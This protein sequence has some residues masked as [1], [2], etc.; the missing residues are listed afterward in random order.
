MTNQTVQQGGRCIDLLYFDVDHGLERLLFLT[1]NREL[2]TVDFRLET[3]P[4]PTYD[5]DGRD[6]PTASLRGATRCASV[7]QFDG[8]CRAL[9]AALRETP[10]SLQDPGRPPF[11][12]LP[13]DALRL[14]VMGPGWL[15]S[16]SPAEFRA[17]LP[18]NSY[19]PV[20]RD[21]SRISCE[22]AAPRPCEP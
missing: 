2:L 16:S 22:P 15:G 10:F 9:L 12:A 11:A 20:G 4:D 18:L 7:D 21:H 17:S 14:D 8:F 19:L 5:Q 1:L 6:V 3:S 13:H